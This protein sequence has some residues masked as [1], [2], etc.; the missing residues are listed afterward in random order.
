MLYPGARCSVKMDELGRDLT[1]V[2][3]NGCDDA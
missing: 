3:K 1:K 2:K